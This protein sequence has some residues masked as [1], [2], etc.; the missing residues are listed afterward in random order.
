VIEDRG[1]GVSEETLSHLFEPFGGPLAYVAAEFQAPGV[2]PA[3][4][5]MLM[6][7]QGGGITLADRP[8][9]GTIVTLHFPTERRVNPAS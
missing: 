6:E 5:R 4:V 2:A 8:S 3:L 7:A 1:P 9:G